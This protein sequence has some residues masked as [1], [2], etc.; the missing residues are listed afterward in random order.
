MPRGGRFQNMRLG[1]SP[2]Y[3]HPDKNRISHAHFHTGRSVVY[4]VNLVPST[5]SFPLVAAVAPP[6][7]GAP[8]P[9][10]PPTLSAGPS[11]VCPAAGGDAPVVDVALPHAGT[12]DGGG[13]A[14]V[15]PS[16]FIPSSARTRL[17][18]ATLAETS[19]FFS[20]IIICGG[21]GGCE[22]L[23]P[24]S[25]RERL[26][27]SSSS[28]SRRRTAAL[29]LPPLPLA[30]AFPA[31][32]FCCFA[33]SLRRLSIRFSIILRDESRITCLSQMTHVRNRPR[34][35]RHASERVSPASEGI[36]LGVLH[37]S[38]RRAR[39]PWGRRPWRLAPWQLGRARVVAARHR[40]SLA[41]VVIERPPPNRLARRELDA[42]HVA[43]SRVE[44]TRGFSTFRERVRAP[45]R[46]RARR[47][48]EL[49]ATR[50]AR[51]RHNSAASLA[52][53]AHSRPSPQLVEQ[54]QQPH[55]SLV[56]FSFAYGSGVYR[57]PVLRLFL[58]GAAGCGADIVM[59]STLNASARKAGI[60][61]PTN[62]RERS[63]TWRALA[64]LLH[65]KF[66]SSEPSIAFTKAHP[67]KTHDV[68]PLL[69]L[70]FPGLVHGY[71]WW[72]W[73]DWDTWVGDFRRLQSFLHG[74]RADI[75]TPGMA[76]WKAWLPDSRCTTSAHPPP[77][78]TMSGASECTQQVSWGPLT[79]V[80]NS[81]AYQL[82]WSRPENQRA[83]RFMLQQDG[84]TQFDE[85]GKYTH[86]HKAKHGA[87]SPV[88]YANSFSGILWRASLRGQLHLALDPKG[89]EQASL[90]A[91]ALSCSYDPLSRPCFVPS[92][93]RPGAGYCRMQVTAGGSTRL[94]QGAQS[95]NV[96]A[97]G[98]VCEHEATIC[99]F[100]FKEGKRAAWRRLDERAVHNLLDAR[101][102][103]A[104]RDASHP[105]PLG[106]YAVGKA[107]IT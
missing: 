13:G 79:V 55:A 103:V 88:G 82:L 9:S 22:L 59:L 20:L 93:L 69:P 36:S 96:S 98:C 29:P 44:F 105:D 51:L 18:S 89:L 17:V 104:T 38:A 87:L 81:P 27:R 6:A 2:T 57:D 26:R 99:H 10:E 23:L 24:S 31:A 67:F 40:L 95:A 4:R 58:K 30:A 64:S 84:N 47:R 46:G 1:G 85:W 53:M 107:L 50:R 86:A 19:P 32:A 49:Y 11:T 33:W 65:R 76:L 101:N 80:R 63:V 83:A 73:V 92:K 21:G 43:L 102:L 16:G 5:A 77:P 41:I 35:V 62:V 75:W 15:P 54:R 56:L 45:S 61:L 28:T 94:F 7:G 39:R 100:P 60:T 74:Y 8:P 14:V 12:A 78:G 97:K 34:R 25:R 71:K 91:D 42:L 48:Y 68:K 106:L 52:A 72:G 3:T 70:L 90:N 37:C 66:A